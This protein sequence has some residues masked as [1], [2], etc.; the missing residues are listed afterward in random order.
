MSQSSILLNDFTSLWNEIRTDA[1]SAVD[2]VGQSGW[3]ILGEEVSAFER[4]L[5]TFSQLPFC[6]GVANGLDAIEISLRA[7]GLKPG[8][9]VLTTPLSA[10]AT[11]LAIIRAGGVPVFV[12]TDENGL[13]DLNAA[14][15]FLG[16]HKDVRF[17]VPV[18]LFG[19][20]ID[21]NELKA[22]RDE[23]SLLIVEDCAQAI[24]AKSHGLPVGSVGQMAA[25][26]FYPTKNLGCLGD[27]GALFT[28]D[29]KLDS[30][31]RCLRDYGQSKKYQHD[32][33]GLNSR[34]DELQAAILRSALLPRLAAFTDIRRK[35]AAH[36]SEGI[37]NPRIRVV[38][39]ATTCFS[40]WHLFPIFVQEQRES[41]QVHLKAHGVS[42]GIHYPI[43]IPHQRAL[44]H[45]SS[46][47]EKFPNA[48][49]MANHE[50]SLPI[51]PYLTEQE[52][53]RIINACNTW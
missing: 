16:S 11:S 51:H 7:L 34:L 28:S 18:H 12:D 14:R 43:I 41:L 3:L 38:R 8:E 24:G 46:A 32:E 19:H 10:F 26:S 35:L 13:L 44:E 15:R 30:A 39:E 21:L 52:V 29:P 23:F 5:A 42:T 25:T 47:H 1:L 17:M 31:A 27:G 2:R 22:L 45:L 50:L 53:D 49:S 40:V 6:V 9:R 48:A 33:L 4:E 36:L 20:A 37:K